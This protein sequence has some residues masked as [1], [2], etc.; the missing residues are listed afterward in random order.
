[1]S[2]PENVT[3]IVLSATPSGEYDKRLVLLTRERGEITA[4]AHGVR[5]TGNPMMAAANPFVFGTFTVYEGRTA[6]TLTQANV[7][8]YFTELANEFPGV[9]YGFYFLEF[10]G[11]YGRENKPEKD[12][13]NLLYLSC[14]ALESPRL[15]NRLI[16]CIFELRAMVINGEYPDMFACASCGRTE[17]LS[18]YSVSSGGMLC[19]SCISGLA[20]PKEKAG[21]QI[22]RTT[23][24]T[25]QYVI[26]APLE[27]LYSFTVTEEVLREFEMVMRRHVGHYTDRKFKSLEILEG[28]L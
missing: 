18:V 14:R 23:V 6:Y 27:K 26:A 17:G 11:Y 3:G 1:M 16:R 24:Y 13:L 19:E 25:M 22:S 5:R 15:E 8:Q 28:M 4:F 21:I 2:E 12:M 10:A 7:K 9:Y 20:F